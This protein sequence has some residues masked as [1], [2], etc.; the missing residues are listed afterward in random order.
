MI[1]T[2][3]NSSKTETTPWYLFPNVLALDAPVVAIIWQHFLAKNFKIELS[4]IETAALF[5]TVWFIYLLDHFLDSKNN[6]YT[7]RRHVFIAKKRKL[8]IF[9][10]TLTF[11][12]SA[13]LTTLLPEFM[14]KGGFIL[15][16]LISVYLWIIHS[17]IINLKIKTNYKELL[18]G[19][20]FGTGVSLP[21]INSELSITTWL[22]SVTLFCLLCW[23]NCKLIDNWESD[24]LRFS[25]LE[26][27]LLLVLFFCMFLSS[28]S[29]VI[30]ALISICLFFIVDRFVGSKNIQLS[31][32]F[33]DVCLLSPCVFWNYQ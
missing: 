24:H 6:I 11:T 31:R 8:A 2:S 12:T 32:V 28:K 33:V 23:I 5:F 27:F 17:N 21:V 20:G 1:P 22:P 13:F 30:A 16:I 10:I 7:T 26:V 9:L 18:V 3:I 15:A 14:I 19:I 25:K 4:G 29:L